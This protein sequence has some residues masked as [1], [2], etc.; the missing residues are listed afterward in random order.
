MMMIFV[1]KSSLLWPFMNILDSLD[2]NDDV[3]NDGDDM[4]MSLLFDND[5][6]DNNINIGIKMSKQGLAGI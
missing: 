1:V 3:Y 6:D 2:S 4:M 5:D